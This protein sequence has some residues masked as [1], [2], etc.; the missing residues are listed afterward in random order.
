MPAKRVSKMS[1]A[2]LTASFGIA[3]LMIAASFATYSVSLPT[4]KIGSQPTAKQLDVKP[5]DLSLAC[6]GAA[7]RLGG[8]NGVKIGEVDRLGAASVYFSSQLSGSQKLLLKALQ[9]EQVQQLGGGSLTS[10]Y[11]REQG[12]LLTVRDDRGDANQS[13]ALL[14]AVQAQKLSSDSAIGLAAVSCQPA[15][16]EQWI[17]GADTTTGREAI[18]LLQNNTAVDSSVDVEIFT[19]G[20]QL[21]TSAATGIAVPANDFTTIAIASFAPKAKTVALHITSRGGAVGAWVQQKTTRGLTRGG[22]EFISPQVKASTQIA[23]PGLFI[24]GS[25]DA[26]K[27]IAQNADYRD[28]TPSLHIY[29]PGEVAATVTVQVISSTEGAF[30]TVLKQAI[31]AGKVNRFE[32]PG[33]SDGD[34]VVL[35]DSDQPIFAEGQMSRV[36]GGKTTDFAYLAPAEPLKAERATT[37]PAGTITR[38]SLLN[39]SDTEVKVQLSG[40]YSGEVVIDKFSAG[41]V[42]LS[43]GVGL[44]ISSEQPVATALVIDS[45]GSISVVPTLTYRNTGK[46]VSVLVR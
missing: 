12:S 13:S 41:D 29:V 34:Y 28:L 1:K 4:W 7:V 42:L 24:R 46:S 10:S 6:P 9:D 27:L 19:D 16:Y 17:V 31:D 38:L 25:S 37:V 35:I 5:K 21:S 8:S 14:T 40:A 22:I 30:G 11:S 44:Q 39:P 20:G 26:Q 33:L 18:L 32:I 43:A 3:A 2:K 23:I 45:A 36:K 15:Q